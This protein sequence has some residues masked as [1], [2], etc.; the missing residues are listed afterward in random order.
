[1]D[2]IVIHGGQRLSG[3]V[4]ISGAKNAALPLMAASLLTKDEIELDNVPQLSDIATMSHLLINHGV[5]LSICGTGGYDALKHRVILK[6]DTITNFRAPYDIVRKMRASV[7]VLGPLLARFGRAEVSM[8]GGCAIGTRPI[9]MHL[10]AMQALGAEIYLHDG[11]IEAVA[12]NGLHGAEINFE[13]VSVGA[14]ENALMAATLASG[15][16]IIRNAAME[17]EIGDLA[18]L[19]NKMGAKISGIG[20]SILE[21]EGVLELHSA[22]HPVIFDRIE[23]G[24]Y[25]VAAVITGGELT[26][27]NVDPVFFSNIADKIIEVGASITY[28]GNIVKVSAHG[29]RKSIDLV[30]GPYPAFP[31]DMQAQLMALLAISEGTSTITENIFENRY[32]HVPELNRMGANI[33]TKGGVATVQGVSHFYGAEVMAT[34]LRASSSLVLAGLSASGET[35]INRVYHLDRGYEKIEDKLA[36]C[37]AKIYRVIS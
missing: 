10:K 17:P 33:I 28:D 36:K 19:L 22:K 29:H 14:T 32:M 12:P 31:T 30:T 13:V 11:Y 18:T 23:A 35:I 34:D 15:K 9:D 7:L 16:T 1:M 6:A 3:S 2:K 37:G 27:E 20:T 24:T 25:A 21:I 26:L 5:K 8:P 4:R